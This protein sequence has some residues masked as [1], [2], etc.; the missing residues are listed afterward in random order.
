MIN[1]SRKGKS[2]IRDKYS[3]KIQD[4]IYKTISKIGE[5]QDDWDACY[6]SNLIKLGAIVYKIKNKT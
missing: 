3:S 5:I 6:C 1:K 4:I 2:K